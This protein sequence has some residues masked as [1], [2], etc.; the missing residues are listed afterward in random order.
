MRKLILPL[1]AALALTAAS[2]FTANSRAEDAAAPQAM[3][4]TAEIAALKISGGWAK[5]M[6][7][8]QPVGG[9]YLTVQ[10]TGSEADRLL[11]ITSPSS[12]DVQIH[13]MKMEGDVMKMRQ[14]AEGLEIPAGGK[15]ELKPGG[16]HLMFMSVP[17]PFKEGGMVKIMLKFEKAG[18][19]EVSLPVAAADSTGPGEMHGG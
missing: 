13:E 4:Q 19:V 11:S 8:G 9:G 18:G 10:N 2:L 7:P 16:S 6:L 12:P 5:A 1:A 14:L 3:M 15:V 17:E